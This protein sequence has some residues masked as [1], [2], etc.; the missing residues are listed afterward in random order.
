[1]VSFV[2]AALARLFGLSTAMSGSANVGQQLLVQAGTDVITTDAAGLHQVTFPVAFPNSLISVVVLGGDAGN[3][4]TDVYTVDIA[5]SNTTKF[6]IA[7]NVCNTGA[8]DA[9]VPARRIN[10]IAVG[11]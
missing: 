9:N 4:R 10:W 2:L 8:N 11:T 1:M 5:N 3:N 6:G 7:L